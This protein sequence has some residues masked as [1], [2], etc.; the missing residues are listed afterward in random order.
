MNKTN[1]YNNKLNNLIKET[2]FL[3]NIYN[4]NE[5]LVAFD[6]ETTGL[7][8]NRDHIISIAAVEIKN[9]RL[10]GNQFQGYI[11]PRI[12]MEQAAINVHKLENNFYD[13]YFT[14]T[15]K[16]DIEVMQNFCNFVGNSILIAYNAIFDYN[17][18]YKELMFWKLPII[19]KNKFF[20]CMKYF[21]KIYGE[22]DP[23]LKKSLTLKRSCDYLGLKSITEDYHSA[24]YDSIMCARLICKLLDFCNSKRKTN[25]VKVNKLSNNN[26][27]EAKYNDDNDVFTKSND[28]SKSIITGLVN[29][30]ND[31]DNNTMTNNSSL[32]INNNN[33]NNNNSNGINSEKDI[34]KLIDEIEYK[35]SSY[36]DNNSI[37]QYEFNSYNNIYKPYYSNNN[38]INDNNNSSNNNNNYNDNCNNNNKN[39]SSFNKKYIDLSLTDDKIY[40]KNKNDKKDKHNKSNSSY[41]FNNS[42]NSITREKTTNK[43]HNQYINNSNNI[44]IKFNCL[45]SNNKDIKDNFS[46]NYKYN[47]NML[48]NTSI[49]YNKNDIINGY[50]EFLDDNAKFYDTNYI[51]SLMEDYINHINNTRNE[52]STNTNNRTK[53]K[54]LK[55]V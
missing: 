18:L 19:P 1:N 3:P 11:T 32:K 53:E 41:N 13:V 22:I 38:N 14:D 28:D 7:K 48:N 45:I 42:N 23:S 5:R 36:V 43:I 46:N 26:L 37:K 34:D 20:C 47:N 44:N 9:G 49:N 8:C 40:F 33:N 24:L 30:K 29:N 39:S 54:L 51:K 10:T 21:K 2:D 27:I 55:F 31:I 4:L 52:I 25:L 35:I 12:K 17:F 15:Y 50:N 6:T 16:S